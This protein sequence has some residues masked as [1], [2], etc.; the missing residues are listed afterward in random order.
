MRLVCRKRLWSVLLSSVLILGACM[1]ASCIANG[2]PPPQTGELRSLPPPPEQPTAP[3]AAP[4]PT[5]KPAPPPMVGN[6]P[7]APEKNALAMTEP[8]PAE[9]PS[10][11]ETSSPSPEV[12]AMSPPRAGYVPSNAELIG[13]DQSAATR[14]LGPA[15]EKSDQPPATVWRY[16]GA[17]CELD[18]F[19]YLDLRSGRMRTL[20]YAF[21]GE[22]ADS[23]K[24]QECLRS[25]IATRGG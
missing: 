2:P 13:L 25:L 8:K 9:G 1:L 22:G 4:R 20:H 15:T 17:S 21:K 12:A 11:L 3:S 5:R 10:G 6:P 23:A 18:L 14:L 24:E 7:P 19:F 16:R